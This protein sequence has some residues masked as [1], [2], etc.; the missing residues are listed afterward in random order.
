MEP[1]PS[2]NS[3]EGAYNPWSVVHLVFEHLAKQGLEPTLGSVQDPARPAEELLIAL[4]VRPS[5]EGDPRVMQ[6][7]HA[8]L[9]EMR[10]AMDPP[11]DG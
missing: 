9:A 5:S 6:E 7:V 2:Q 3:N 4:G 11:S 10:A 1:T 8:Q